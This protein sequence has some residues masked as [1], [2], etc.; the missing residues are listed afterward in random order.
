MY[1]FRKEEI[2]IRR[3]QSKNQTLEVQECLIN[4]FDSG[5]FLYHCAFVFISLTFCGCW[6]CFFMLFFLHHSVQCV[7]S[8]AF[9]EI[10]LCHSSALRGI[11]WP[12]VNCSYRVLYKY[13]TWSCD[14]NIVLRQAAQQFLQTIFHARL[15]RS[16]TFL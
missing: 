6:Q 5:L 2:Q 10:Q 13:K 16:N 11:C 7:C 15:C 4:G 14:T 8:M 9:C 3:L 1:C 12:S